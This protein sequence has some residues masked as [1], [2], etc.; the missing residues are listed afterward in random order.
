MNSI[1][2]CIMW[3]FI[4][5]VSEFLLRNDVYAMMLAGIL[6]MLIMRIT[7]ISLIMRIL[8]LYA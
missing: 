6:I 2:V 4:N 8:L 7:R 1:S 3:T 5:K